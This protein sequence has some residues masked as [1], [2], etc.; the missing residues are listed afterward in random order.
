MITV[1]ATLKK[2]YNTVKI[3]YKYNHINYVEKPAVSRGV[4]R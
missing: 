3:L 2:F 4:T 1:I